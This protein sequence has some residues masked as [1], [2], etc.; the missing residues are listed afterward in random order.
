MWVSQTKKTKALAKPEVPEVT[1]E[2][3]TPP[4]QS[5][6]SALQNNSLAYNI[7]NALNVV[8]ANSGL[9]SLLGVSRDISYEELDDASKKVVD[10]L[11]EQLKPE[12]EEKATAL[13]TA[14]IRDRIVRK[15]NIVDVGK[16]LQKKKTVSL[17]RKK[18][19]IFV[20]FGSGE[21]EDPIEELL[22]AST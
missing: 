9:T 3:V 4:I 11:M 10:A 7:S 21:P 8:M 5:T 1:A 15:A 16:A 22:I 13:L 2:V 18:G 6:V 19:C 20:Q 12:I 14:E 17:K